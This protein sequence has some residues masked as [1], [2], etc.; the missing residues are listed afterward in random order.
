[1][2]YAIL[3]AY[4]P[5]MQ[6]N[7]PDKTKIETINARKFVSGSYFNGEKMEQEEDKYSD[8]LP[9]FNQV[10]KEWSRGMREAILILVTYILYVNYFNSC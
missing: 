2:N 1:M 9:S 10:Y 4:R 3:I 7:R 5:Q 8:T 6:N